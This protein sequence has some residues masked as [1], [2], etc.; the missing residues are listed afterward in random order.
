[1]NMNNKTINCKCV[2]D[3]V[4]IWTNI[5]NIVLDPCEH[6]IH[7]KCFID[8]TK[9]PLC[10]TAV[11]NYYNEKE[12]AKL[13]NEDS[14]YYQKYVDLISLKNPSYMSN[15]NTSKVVERLPMTIDIISK[16][17][18]SK[19]FDKM[20]EI[21]EKLMTMFNTKLTVHGQNNITDQ[22]KIIISTHTCILD[23][24]VIGYLFKCGFLSSV[25]LLKSFVGR[26]T[27]GLIPFLLLDR[28]KKEK[29]VDRMREYVKNV[30]SLCLYP[31]GMMTH[32]DTIIQFRTGA[33]YT[34][35]PIQPV[36]IKYDQTVYDPSFDATV[37]KLL[38]T[39]EMNI[40]VFVLPVEYPPFDAKKIEIIRKNMAKIGNMALSRV[41]NK[42]IIE[43]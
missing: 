28:T 1:M 31:E 6:I 39:D 41:S 12:L 36:V 43:D 21:S 35:H 11:T 4:L 40:E 7:R 2:C 3:K 27:V 33:F 10:K 13:C 37:Q 23:H 42:D 5:R 34:G 32:P 16:V 24:M 22:R 30:E 15:V 20:H 25:T 38:S 14:S 8:K 19:G 17:L 9:C 26:I 29:T 18:T